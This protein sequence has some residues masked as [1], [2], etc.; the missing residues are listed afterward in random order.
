[1]EIKKRTIKC[2][3]CK[4][5]ELV[6]YSKFKDNL[7]YEF[8]Y[9]C[10]CILGQKASSSIIT[11]PNIVAENLALENYKIFEKIEIEKLPELILE[12][13]ERCKLVGQKI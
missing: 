5:S 10:T 6:I 9:K 8:A 7:K 3:I 4:D 13:K 2:W 12:A 11:V 1:M